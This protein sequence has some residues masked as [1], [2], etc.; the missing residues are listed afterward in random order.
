MNLLMNFSMKKLS[1]AL[2]TTWSFASVSAEVVM[3]KN[4][5]SLTDEEITLAASDLSEFEMADMQKNPA[6]LISFIEQLFD[7]KVMAKSIEK[8][9]VKDKRFEVIRDGMMDKFI[10]GYYIKQKALEKI[11]AVKDYKTLAK[12]TY[13]TNLK[14]YQTPETKDFYHVLFIKQADED[15]KAKAEQVAQEIKDKKLTIAEAAKKYHSSVAGTNAD[16]VLEKVQ[17]KQLMQAIQ[18][19][20]LAMPVGAVSDVIETDA[21]YH[22]ISLKQVNPPETKPYDDKIEAEIIGDIKTKMYRGVNKDIRDQYRGQKDLTVNEE[23]LKSVTDKL[24]QQ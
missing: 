23:L 24:L 8:T 9:L 4:G 1:L 17:I 5:V 22:I 2:L 19:A 16:G 12:Q 10:N 13:Q 6:M 11:N 14:D 18:K 7:N 15:N 20:V 21:G 3:E